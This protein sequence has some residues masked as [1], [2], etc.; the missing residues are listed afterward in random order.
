MYFATKLSQKAK[1]YP[2]SSSHKKLSKNNAFLKS[3]TRK[4]KKKLHFED[5]AHKKQETNIIIKNISI[6]LQISKELKRTNSSMRW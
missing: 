3:S 2:I 6:D 4:V 5:E 1:K